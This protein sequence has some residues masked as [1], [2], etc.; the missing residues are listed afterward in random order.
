MSIPRSHSDWKFYLGHET[1]SM[2]DDPDL[3]PCKNVVSI[4][5]PFPMKGSILPQSSVLVLVIIQL[6]SRARGAGH[7]PTAEQ[8]IQSHILCSAGTPLDTLPVPGQRVG[9]FGAAGSLSAWFPGWKYATRVQNPVGAFQVA[10][11]QVL[12]HLAERKSWSLSGNSI[13]SLRHSLHLWLLSGRTLDLPQGRWGWPW[14]LFSTW[15]ILQL[16]Q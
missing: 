14:S 8:Q 15:C 7:V 2:Q 6:C 4:N 3:W 11:C 1:M 9:F 5:L 10:V 16:S 12:N 13:P